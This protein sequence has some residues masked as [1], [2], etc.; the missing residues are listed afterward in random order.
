MTTV[1]GMRR[2]QK[3][4]GQAGEAAAAALPARAGVAAEIA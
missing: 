2:A 1:A 4:A 3:A